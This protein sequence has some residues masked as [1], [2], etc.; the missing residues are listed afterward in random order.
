MIKL[1]KNLL[2][3]LLLIC[4]LIASA[5]AQE[6]KLN[7]SFTERVFENVSF[8]ESFY[9][10]EKQKFVFI[11]GKM[12]VS[13]PS[14]DP[15]YDIYISLV[16]T[17]T[18]DGNMQN[19]KGRYATQF[20]YIGG[21]K[22]YGLIANTTNNVTL[23]DDFDFDN[24]ND[25]VYVNNTHVLVNLTLLGLVPVRVTDGSGFN[26]NLTS[27]NGKSIRINSEIIIAG[28]LYGRLVINGTYTGSEAN[29]TIPSSWNAKF[30]KITNNVTL[31][32]PELRGHESTLINYTIYAQ[33]GDGVMVQSP[34]DLNTEYLNSYSTKILAGHEFVVR[35]KVTNVPAQQGLNYTIF[36]LNITMA[37]VPVPWNGTDFN[38]SYV[39]L[40]TSGDYNNV[41]AFN[42]TNG[43][44]KNVTDN[45]NTRNNQTW[46]WVPNNGSLNLGDSVN[47]TYIIKAP[48]SVPSS[49]TYKFMT[50]DIYFMIFN[51][52]SN[53]TVT[54]V[55]SASQ[56]QFNLSKQIWNESND[57][58]NHNV[59]WRVDAAVSVPI[60][61]TYN[62]S[63]VTL[64]VSKNLNP[65]NGTGLTMNYTLTSLLNQST[66]WTTDT[67]TSWY[68]DYTDGSSANFPPPIIWMKPY[69]IIFNGYNQIVN[70]SITNV[71]KD[72]Y[73]KY[74]Y[75]V[76]GYWL[77][78]DKKIINVGQDIYNI[79]IQVLNIGNGYTPAGYVVQVY[80]FIPS[81]FTPSGFN[82]GWNANMTTNQ[83]NY[84]GTAYQ[85]VVSG[86][87]TPMN[88]SF[89]PKGHVSGMDKWNATY[90][91]QGIGDYKVTDLYIVGLDPMRVDGAGASPLIAIVEGLQNSSYEVIFALVVLV[92]LVINVA[93]LVM[94]QRIE[95]KLEKVKH[96]ERHYDDLKEE[97]EKL[98]EKLK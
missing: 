65:G 33:A 79:T 69:Y 11:D 94:S 50:Q 25:S 26:S 83:P 51:V 9:L 90:S 29:N 85:W 57:E 24:I 55:R 22:E 37:L 52:V 59:T 15:V 93:N 80:D 72:L 78:V 71:G 76:N 20:G 28:T 2:L 31:F 56:L 16:N 66:S 23:Q 42:T 18:F 73:L 48:D 70:Q 38:F 41:F 4:A 74:I 8:A 84:N 21:F 17:R 47:I 32:I 88:A 58:S 19:E 45:L 68:F 49:N 86:S 75:V 35:D 43:D 46:Y 53:L 34:L 64:W 61:T 27:L 1:Y 81:G 91:V 44:Y 98:K 82:P 96:Q 40:S 13:N 7:I 97:I 54:E 36:V 30:K 10:E 89:A 5:F 3:F 87:R 12:N 14:N 60:N 95:T 63:K 67:S 62:V 77:S 6:A 39:N 92:L